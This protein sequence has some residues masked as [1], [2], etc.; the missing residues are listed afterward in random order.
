MDK[1][2]QIG[3]LDP[4]KRRKNSNNLRVYSVKGIS[5]SLCADMTGW[6]TPLLLVNTE[7]KR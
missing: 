4:N 1:V 5:P 7:R 2:I 3:N 6:K